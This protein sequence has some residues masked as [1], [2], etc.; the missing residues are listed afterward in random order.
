MSTLD[1]M[2]EFKA[3]KVRQLEVITG[4]ATSTAR[5]CESSRVGAGPIGLYG[6]PDAASFSLSR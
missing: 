4:A 2:L 5:I 3:S 6:K 1:H